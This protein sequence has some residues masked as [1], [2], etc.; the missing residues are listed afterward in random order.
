M[1]GMSDHSFVDFM[2]IIMSILSYLLCYWGGLFCTLHLE[3]M[4]ILFGM[5]GRGVIFYIMMPCIDTTLSHLISE[6]E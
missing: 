5:T 2:Y 6:Y 1:K 3:H 4:V